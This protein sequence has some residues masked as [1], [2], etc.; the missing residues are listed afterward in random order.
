[1]NEDNSLE[2]ASGVCIDTDKSDHEEDKEESTGVFDDTVESLQ[3]IAPLIGLYIS[4]IHYK[5]INISILYIV[6]FYFR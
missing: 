1:M 5:F 3:R 6:Y 4:N 2:N